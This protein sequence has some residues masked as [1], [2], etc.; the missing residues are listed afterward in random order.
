VGKEDH[1]GGA[2]GGLSSRRKG[3]HLATARGT[4]IPAFAASRRI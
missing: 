2:E 1:E 4:L 3:I